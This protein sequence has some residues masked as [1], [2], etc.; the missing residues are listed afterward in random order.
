[1]R[2][3]AGFVAAI[4]CGLLPAAGSEQPGR[5]EDSPGEAVRRLPAERIKAA[6]EEHI[7]AK[8]RTDGG[9]YLLADEQTGETLRLEFLHLAIVSD[10]GLWK[11]HDPHRLVEGRAFFACVNFH[12]QGSPEKKRYDVD[13]L[14]KDRDGKLEVSDV[15]IHMVPRLVNGKWILQE[16]GPGDGPAAKK[17]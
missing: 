2:F 14:L 4:S 6:V 16:R 7:Q 3:V 10:S 15:R 5:R 13:F 11:V 9:V 1:M 8:A 17:P 12:P